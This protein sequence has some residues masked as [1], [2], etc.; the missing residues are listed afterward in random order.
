MNTQ[1]EVMSPILFKD[2]EEDQFRQNELGITQNKICVNKP[3]TDSVL[4]LLNK[5]E[6]LVDSSDEEMFAISACNKTKTIEKQKKMINLKKLS[7]PFTNKFWRDQKKRFKNLGKAIIEN[8][9]K[10]ELAHLQKTYNKNDGRTYEDIQKEL[11]IIYET[12]SNQINFI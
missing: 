8:C 9:M 12:I 6:R 10:T 4:N 7:N 2:E 5:T 11:D 3:K 1:N